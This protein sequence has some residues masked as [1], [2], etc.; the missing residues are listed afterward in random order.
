M[1]L[2]AREHLGHE[3][4]DVALVHF[5]KADEHF[6]PNSAIQSIDQKVDVDMGGKKVLGL[7][8]AKRISNDFDTGA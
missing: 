4:F 5:F 6:V 2:R 8:V 1:A 3:F 7:S